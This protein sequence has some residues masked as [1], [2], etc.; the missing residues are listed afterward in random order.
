MSCGTISIF[1]ALAVVSAQA[2]ER[3]SRIPGPTV[4]ASALFTE[5]TS[6]GVVRVERDGY[7]STN[8]DQ[9][10]A[11]M[12]FKMAEYNE[13]FQL[14]C[15]VNRSRFT[16]LPTDTFFD[17][18]D[19]VQERTK[20]TPVILE[21]KF[22]SV[23][24]WMLLRN[25]SIR[26]SEVTLDDLGEWGCDLII[27]NIETRETDWY[28]VPVVVTSSLQLDIGFTSMKETTDVTHPKTDSEPFLSTDTKQPTEEFAITSFRIV[29]E[30]GSLH[31]NCTSNSWWNR[32]R[33]TH[34]PTDNFVE[35]IDNTRDRTKT[36]LIS[37]EHQFDNLGEGNSPFE[38]RIRVMED[39]VM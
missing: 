38:C 32:C 1:M 25:C 35:I 5:E 29:Q 9:D 37:S 34:L 39:H 10:P 2:F 12:L 27:T 23:D 33:F 17:I 3:I 28:G 13:I 20:T 22:P 24:D 15:T 36:T 19:K 26:M 4:N 31:L 16:Q 21:H 8:T 7:F 18:I 11:A 6:I 30:M 14:E